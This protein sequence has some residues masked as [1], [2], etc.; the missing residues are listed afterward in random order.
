MI[1]LLTIAA[2]MSAPK[3][4]ELKT[5]KDWTVGCDNGRRCQ[6]V[7]LMPENAEERLTMAVERGPEPNAVPAIRFDGDAEVRGIMAGG[8][9]LPV[10]IVTDKNGSPAVRPDGVPALLAAIRANAALEALDGKGAKVG[11]LS[12]AGSNA[13]LLYMDEQQRRIGTVTAL[14]RPGTKPAS[15]VP[16]PPP[17]PVIV[18]V[19]PDGSKP[20]ARLSAAETAALRKRNSC[21]PEFGPRDHPVEVQS[22]GGGATLALIPCS[23]GAYNGT[24]LVLVARGKGSF[25]PARFDYAASAGEKTGPEVPPDGAF[26]NAEGRRLESAFKGRGLGDCGVWQRWAWDGTRFRLS[27]ETAMGEC[28]GS[29]DYITTWRAEVR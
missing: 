4:G 28:R 22:L 17:L 5:F 6:A 25:R 14:A 13:A 9:R 23:Q 24:S 16:A 18:S 11:R 15:T 26:W 27:E 8:K 7:A 2:A 20:A 19:R 21:D 12:L 1:L 10:A 3:P 29:T